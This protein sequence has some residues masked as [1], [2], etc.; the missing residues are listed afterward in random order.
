MLNQLITPMNFVL[1]RDYMATLIANERDQQLTLADQAGKTQE[2]IENN[3]YFDVY[4]A[5]WRPLDNSDMPAI[6]VYVDNMN[7]PTDRQ[8]GSQNYSETV[9]NIDCFAVGANGVDEFGEVTIT[10]EQ[11]ADI[12]LNYMVS[13]AYK[14]LFSETNWAKGAIGIVRVPLIISSYRIDEPELNNEGQVVLGYR[15]QLQLGF[16]EPTQMVTGVDI[17]QLYISLKIRDEYIDP[18]VNINL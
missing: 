1:V 4:S 12:R 14:I 3:Y 9:F 10:A 17:E 11:S 16:K 2:E 8:Y 5:L 7:F 18:F 13:Q 6:A 15:L